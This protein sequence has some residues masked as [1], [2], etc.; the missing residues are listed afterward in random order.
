MPALKLFVSHSSR[1]DDV[2]H[3]WTRA[4]RNWCLLDDT[5]KA[6]RNHYGDRL[7]V[8]VDKDGLV[9]GDQWNHRLNLW[10]AECHVAIILVSKRALER[11]DWVAK[12]A[13]ILSWR[14]EIDPSFTLIPV[15]L[16]GETTA[17]DLTRG[18]GGSIRFG[19]SQ[20]I[21]DACS[22]AD[23]LAGLRR[24]LGE[25]DALPPVHDTPLDLLRGGI[26]KL[27]ADGSTTASLEAALAALQC[28]ATPHGMAH[29]LHCADAI[30]RRL[31]DPPPQA[32]NACFANFKLAF[33]A[34]NPPPQSE[35]TLH[36]FGSVRSLWVA[37][38]AAAHLPRA[39]RERTPIAL[40]G[41][42]T[43]FVDR[44]L[45]T[46]HYTL[47]RYLERA[48]PK[49]RPWLRIPVTSADDLE[50]IRRRIR[51]KAFTPAAVAAV[52]P[53]KLDER[54]NADQRWPILV[55]ATGK[56]SGGAPDTR[57]MRELARLQSQ[58][59]KLILV[60]TAEPDHEPL[61]AGIDLVEP[62]LDPEVEE[63][64]YVDESGTCMYLKQFYGRCG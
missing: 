45:G 57:R 24:Q 2:P 29:H 40:A 12:E 16:Q 46:E 32:P 38:G 3:K 25:P 47:D 55:V 35:R 61:P 10:L 37:P 41:A 52:N 7:D 42:K 49:T 53:E 17:D 4:D 30:A 33:Q 44:D 50:G 26:A 63:N 64:A 34:L 19:D 18:F 54:L 48:W 13:A 31:F 22:A 8:L 60:L 28:P 20:C 14:A 21:R 58:Y 9:P 62:E 43:H 15:A 59:P 36:L 39:L 5:C 11:S 6:I 56:D 23:I 1:L 51:E 27:L